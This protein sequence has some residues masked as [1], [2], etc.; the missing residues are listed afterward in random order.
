VFSW[1]FGV[2]GS[3]P[4]DLRRLRARRGLTLGALAEESGIAKAT[5]SNL[6]SGIGNPTLETL[7]T[8]LTSSLA[9]PRSII[10]VPPAR[11]TS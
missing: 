1:E 8:R 2:I 10:E 4:G 5:L 11:W 3:L 9:R 7:S 6:E